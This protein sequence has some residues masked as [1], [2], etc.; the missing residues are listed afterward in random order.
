MAIN[1]HFEGVDPFV[2][3]L[4]ENSPEPVRVLVDTGFSAELMLQKR[5]IS[6]LGLPEIGGDTY[7]TASGA[8]VETTIHVGSIRWFGKTVAVPILATEGNASLLGMG[9]LFRRHLYMEPSANVLLI[10]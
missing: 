3:V 6:S 1:G 2:E 9:L 8:E 4:F 7:T 10:E 5:T